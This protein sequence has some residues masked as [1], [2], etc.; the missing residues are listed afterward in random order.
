[1][2]DRADRTLKSMG[3]LMI[4]AGLLTIST[5]PAVYTEVTQSKFAL[6]G[7]DRL[8]DWFQALNAISYA[9]SLLAMFTSLL[10]VQYILHHNHDHSEY[11]GGIVGTLYTLAVASFFVSVFAAAAALVIGVSTLLSNAHH[12]ALA[13]FIVIISTVL[14]LIPAFGIANMEIRPERQF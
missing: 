11:L 9:L 3:M 7:N 13:A 14:L 6:F 2:G 8:P 10:N 5:Y 12:A 4:V 1:M